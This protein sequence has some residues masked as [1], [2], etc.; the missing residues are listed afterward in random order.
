MALDKAIEII[1]AEIA[2]RVLAKKKIHLGS[3][4]TDE[5]LESLEQALTILNDANN[6]NSLSVNEL[7]E[8]SIELELPKT[9]EINGIMYQVQKVPCDCICHRTG[10]KHIV[11]CCNNG[12]KEILRKIE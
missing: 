3:W 5:E 2:Q 8:D 11:A 10:G 9:R 1:K 4:I 6:H 7:E 12:Y